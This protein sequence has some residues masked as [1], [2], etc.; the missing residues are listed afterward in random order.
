MLHQENVD[1]SRP[2][3]IIKQEIKSHPYL[4]RMPPIT[5]S[6]MIRGVNLFIKTFPADNSTYQIPSHN[7]KD[8]RNIQWN[9]QP[10]RWDQLHQQQSCNQSTAWC[11]QRPDK[12]LTGTT[13]LGNDFNAVRYCTSCY[14]QGHSA[15]NC[16]LGWRNNNMNSISQTPYNV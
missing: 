10:L 5:D 1:S 8:P 2:P 7:P 9:Q 13:Q 15:Q 3:N 6:N 16:S 12:W 11:N 14:Q 4:V